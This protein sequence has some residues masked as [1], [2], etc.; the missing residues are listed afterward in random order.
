MERER[1]RGRGQGREGERSREQ[2]ERRG[3]GMIDAVGK[4]MKD[5]AKFQGYK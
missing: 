1:D 5:S 4:K 3:G 2:E